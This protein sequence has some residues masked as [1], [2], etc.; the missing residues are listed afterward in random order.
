M[1]TTIPS[2]IDIPRKWRMIDATGLTLGRLASTVAQILMG[3]Q[4][5]LYTP[6]LDMGD[7]V[8]VF[9]AAKIQVT[10]RK[11]R[12]KV[13][14]HYSG[15]PGG[16]KQRTLGERLEKDPE[17]VIQDAV[18][19]ML[20]KTR[21]GRAMFRKL[22]VYREETPITLLTSINERR[23]ESAH[24]RTRVMRDMRQWV[25]SLTPAAQSKA[26]VYVNNQMYSAK[27]LL[28]EITK[29]TPLGRK[30]VEAFFEL[31]NLDDSEEY[32]QGPLKTPNLE[33]VGY[34][35][36]SRKRLFTAS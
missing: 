8:I 28:D 6:F 5:P 36:E 19:G 23:P 2:G 33:K 24:F 13:Y 9:H 4:N 26:A 18:R 17:G 1:S 15:Y 30:F 22:H 29:D 20:P 7:R 25:A 21:L 31:E 3:K 10:G 27:D 14:R 16:L 34:E 32:T 12:D 11:R 35:P